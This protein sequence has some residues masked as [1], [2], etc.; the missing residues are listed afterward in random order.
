MKLTQD[1]WDTLPRWMQEQIAEH[2]E[3]EERLK[4]RLKEGPLE[5][6]TPKGR[7]HFYETLAEGEP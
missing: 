3:N 4:A 2:F 7:K 5:V 1:I 6:G